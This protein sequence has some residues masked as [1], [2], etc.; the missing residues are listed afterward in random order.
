MKPFVCRLTLSIVGIFVVIATKSA[1]AAGTTK[2]ADEPSLFDP[3]RHMR[4][5]EVRPGMK[6]YGL[7]V[8][9]GTKIERFEVE[10]VSVLHNFNPKYDVVLIKCRGANLELTGAVAGRS[11]PPGSV[12]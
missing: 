11:G 12:S 7:S 5:S 9:M 2:P 1:P 10:V 6:G 3:S 8:F 4:V